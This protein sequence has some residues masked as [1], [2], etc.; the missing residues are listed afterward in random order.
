MADLEQLLADTAARIELTDRDAFADDTMA[1]IET[2]RRRR[3]FTVIDG[4]HA[5]LLLAA[6][7]ALIALMSAVLI[8]PASRDA[9]AD[10]FG[11][12]G[13]RVETGAPPPPPA[14]S[15][16]IPTAGAPTSGAPTTAPIP[17]FGRPATLDDAR[18]VRPALRTLRELGSPAAAFIDETRGKLVTLA[19][20]ASPERP[21]IR[22]H[23]DY[24]VVLQQFDSF[25]LALGKGIGN[26]NRAQLTQVEGK[27]AYWIEGDH[28][29]E[30]VSR[31]G[32]ISDSRR[33]ASNALIW[34]SGAVTYRIESN[35][36][37]DRALALSATLA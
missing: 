23:G 11:I 14:E 1:A 22:S 9:V 8:V 16:T 27:Q 5:R 17:T 19:W 26:Q 15:T 28:S 25:E 37:L 12:G 10:L 33:W 21:G 24:G 29:I 34:E 13:V 31:N 4:G 2:A 30:L 7:A 36:S 3:R 20:P 6:A 32:V 35:L 18:R